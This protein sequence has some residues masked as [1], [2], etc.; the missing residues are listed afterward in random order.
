MR[1][2]RAYIL[3]LRRICIQVPTCIHE[4]Q[5]QATASATADTR[6]LR[7]QTPSASLAMLSIEHVP[8]KNSMRKRYKYAAGWAAIGPSRESSMTIY[9]PFRPA[10]SRPP[11]WIV[12]RVRFAFKTLRN[13]GN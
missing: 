5:R 3:Q 13:M 1:R 12:L 11:S 2:G 9:P 10:R 8:A 4:A 7:R 6:E